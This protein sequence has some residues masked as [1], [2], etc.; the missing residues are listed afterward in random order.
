MG[1][2]HATP[3]NVKYRKKIAAHMK[4]MTGHADYS[5]FI[6]EADEDAIAEDFN[7]TPSQMRDLKA[8][9]SMCKQVDDWTFLHYYGWDCHTL[10]ETG[11]LY[12]RPRT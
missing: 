11:T 6:Q 9:Y 3:D 7:F 10:A 1:N 4:E 8:G 2:V 5:V 12:G